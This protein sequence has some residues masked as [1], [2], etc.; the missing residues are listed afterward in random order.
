MLVFFQANRVINNIIEL[1][2]IYNLTSMMHSKSVGHI[3]FFGGSGTASFFMV[4]K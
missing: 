1:K 4:F 3:A 2:V